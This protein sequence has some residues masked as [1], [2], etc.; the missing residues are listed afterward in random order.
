MCDIFSFK[1]INLNVHIAL[2]PHC[3]LVANTFTVAGSSLKRVDSFY[4]ILHLPFHLLPHPI[5][6]CHQ[7]IQL[8]L[9]LLLLLLLLLEVSELDLDGLLQ[10][11]LVTFFASLQY[12]LSFTASIFFSNLT[13]KPTNTSF[14]TVA[15]LA[16]SSSTSYRII[17]KAPSK[18]GI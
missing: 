3:Y 6:V 18:V 17:L 5:L 12:N 14:L 13:E 1:I 2:M 4:D 8:P 15:L 11:L 7:W 10:F 16:N 9:L